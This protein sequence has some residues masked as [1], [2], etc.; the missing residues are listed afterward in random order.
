MSSNKATPEEIR[1]NLAACDKLHDRKYFYVYCDIPSRTIYISSKLNENKGR[2]FL[3]AD[4]R[5]CLEGILRLYGTWINIGTPHEVK[6]DESWDIYPPIDMIKS[7]LKE[8]N[9]E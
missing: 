4:Y 3:A 8:V 7:V 6:V 9:H 5:K 2:C 1:K